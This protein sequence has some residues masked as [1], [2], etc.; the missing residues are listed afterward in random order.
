[1]QHAAGIAQSWRSNYA[2]AY[3]D[4]LDL[5]GEYQEEPEGDAPVWKEWHT[6]VLKETVIQANANV[7][8]LQSSADSSF[9]YW[10]RVS[11]LEQGQ[12]VLLPIKLTEYH[13][14]ALSGKTLDTSTTLVRK[15]NGWWLTLSYEEDVKVAT[16]KDAP[17]IGLDVGIANFITASTGQQYGTFHGKLAERHKRDREKRRR[18]AK[19][20]A[21]LK[22][23][24]VKRLPSTRNK[25]LARTVRQEINRAVNEV[26]RDHP[27]AQFAYEQLSVA[28]MKF[29]AWRMN[30]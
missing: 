19:L 23:K 13:R 14:Q 2:V 5:L 10:L 9:D 29:K 25:K 27:E 24:G 20:R 3:Q 26:Y 21:C 4:Y 8:L 1:M 12:P 16:P 6:P 28:G 11:T 7:A 18:K 30:A 15:H 22:K 17:V